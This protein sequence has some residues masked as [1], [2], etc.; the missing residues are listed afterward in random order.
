[1]LKFGTSDKGQ[2]KVFRQEREFTGLARMLSRFWLFVA[3]WTVARQAPLFVPWD[4]PARISKKMLLLEERKKMHRRKNIHLSATVKCD[5]LFPQYSC[6]TSE[7][8]SISINQR[9][10][11][12]LS[13]SKEQCCLWARKVAKLSFLLSGKETSRP[14]MQSGLSFPPPGDLPNTGTKATSLASPVWA[15]RFF[16]TES[17]GK[18]LLGY[19]TERSRMR[20]DVGH[21]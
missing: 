21:Y 12:R 9:G 10:K 6:P 14:M 20:Y 7:Y 16:T 2:L 17:P 18:H 5:L 1:M 19:I 13:H 4:Y 3:P 15:G 11:W 8:N